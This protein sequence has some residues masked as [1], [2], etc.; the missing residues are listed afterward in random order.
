MFPSDA[1]DAFAVNIRCRNCSCPLQILAIALPVGA[2]TEPTF[3]AALKSMVPMVSPAV[4]PRSLFMMSP[5]TE[6]YINTVASA[7]PHP[8]RFN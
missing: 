7:L 5:G 3:M 1:P 8:R 4:F 2:V 6:P